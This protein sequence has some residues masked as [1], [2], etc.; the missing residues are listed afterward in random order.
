MLFNRFIKICLKWVGLLVRLLGI[1]GWIKIDSL[2]CFLWVFGV[3]KVKILLILLCSWN[4]I[5]FSFMVLVFN[6]EKFKILLIMVNKLLV[7][8]LMV[9]R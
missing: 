9:L 3:N 8:S 6:L 7:D 2:S 1:C 5:D 4:C